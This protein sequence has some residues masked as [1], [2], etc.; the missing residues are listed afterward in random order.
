MN[1]INIGSSLKGGS[2]INYADTLSLFGNE[3]VL[4]VVWKIKDN[5]MRL[6]SF[7]VSLRSHGIIYKQH[8][9]PRSVL[10]ID[11]LIS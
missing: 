7:S 9:A 4:N 8:F 2:W 11:F 10:S 6:Y 5:N 3:E 1:S